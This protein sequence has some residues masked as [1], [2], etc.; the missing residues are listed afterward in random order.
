MAR[1]FPQKF[2]LEGDK[3]FDLRYG[4]N[5][6]QEGAVYFFEDTN[7][8]LKNLKRLTGR[9][10]SL[11]N[12][13]DI[14]A[15]LAS[16]RLFS[17][18]AA[19]IIKHNTPCGIALGESSEQALSR[20]IEA[21]PESAFGGIIVLNSPLDLKTAEVIAAFRDERRGN[22]DVVAAPTVEDDALE[23]LKQVRKTMAIY[24]FGEIPKNMQ[25]FDIKAIDG[26]FII[27]D[28]DIN[29]EEGFAAWKV[30]SEKQP[31]D[32]QIKQMQVAWKFVTRIKSNCVLIVDS[33]IPMTR[34]IGTGQ[35]SRVRSTKIALDQAGEKARGAILASDSFFPFPD[36]IALAA[37]SGITAI[38]QQG[39]SINDQAS[40]EEADKH[41]MVMIFTG[42]RAFWH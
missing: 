35:T 22:I 18:P 37:K 2:K 6:H 4:E 36:S 33:E 20:A 31:T 32:E 7:S 19:V 27:Q 3:A 21:D 25:D 38:V 29:I 15:G 8:P 16:V 24:S 34:G 28:A 23:L 10:G 9:E 5:P 40:V 14:N 13:T 39:G 11:I 30:V 12:I 42:R 17:E 1:N 26:G 41:G